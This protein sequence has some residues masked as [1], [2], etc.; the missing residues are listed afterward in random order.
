[1]EIRVIIKSEV[2]EGAY[3]VNEYGEVFTRVVRNGSRKGTLGD[4]WIKLRTSSNKGY[5]IVTL[6]GRDGVKK[7]YRIGRL[8]LET[9]SGKCPEGMECCH[10]PAGKHDDSLSNLS[11]GT[12]RKN[13]LED[14]LRDGTLL[15]GE[16]NPACKLSEENV[17]DIRR[18]SKCMLQAD[19]ARMYGVSQQ[20]VSEILTK[21]S[22]SMG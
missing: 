15:F 6:T 2:L 22:R 11:W 20:T 5:A 1:M 21:K 17:E 9:F 12:K 18:F 10:G 7:T 4:V 3:G 14:R 16:R 8:V 13:L 19:L